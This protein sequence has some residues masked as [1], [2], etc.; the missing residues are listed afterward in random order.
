MKR[1]LSGGRSSDDSQDVAGDGTVPW[2]SGKA[3]PKGRTFAIDGY[4]HQGCYDHERVRQ[5]SLWALTRL[6]QEAP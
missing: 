3:I 2:Q 5:F 1:D 4:D 6:V